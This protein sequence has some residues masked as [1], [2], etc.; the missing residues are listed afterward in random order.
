M[1]WTCFFQ[2]ICEWQVKELKLVNFFESIMSVISVTWVKIFQ[3]CTINFVIL[4]LICYY[5]VDLT[6]L[7]HRYHLAVIWYRA[8]SAIVLSPKILLLRIEFTIANGPNTLSYIRLD[9][10]NSNCT[11]YP[12]DACT[13]F[14]YLPYLLDLILPMMV[15]VITCHI[16]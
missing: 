13:I 15:H 9:L 1:N 7:G 5:N 4:M 6:N 14:N 12:L 3:S 11:S 16:W 2:R 8:P 10:W